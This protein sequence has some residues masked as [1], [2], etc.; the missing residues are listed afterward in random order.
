MKV[1]LKVMSTI[2]FS[3]LTKSGIYADGMAVEVKSS[4]QKIIFVFLDSS[5]DT[6][7]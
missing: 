1:A 5:W 2:L 6:D 3:C 7:W 4:H